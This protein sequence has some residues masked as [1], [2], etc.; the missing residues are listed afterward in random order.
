[1]R[2]QSKYTTMNNYNLKIGLLTLAAK[3]IKGIGN[4]FIRDHITNEEFF[5]SGV[6]SQITFLLKEK[7]EISEDLIYEV[8]ETSKEI[9]NI[10][11]EENIKILTFFDIDFP[12]N[13]KE[14]KNAPAL[15]FVKG[16]LNLL[17]ANTTCIIGTRKPNENGIRIT[18]K[19]SEHYVNKKWNICNG[20]ADGIDTAAIQNDGIY[21]SNVIGVVAGGLAF[22]TKKTLLKK[23]SIN[24]ENVIEAGGVIIS[25]FLPHEKETTFSVMKSCK[26]QADISDGLILIQSSVDGGSKYTLKS[27]CETGRPIAVINPVK[28]DEKLDSYSG[29]IA[30]RDNSF[31]GLSQITGLKTEKINTKSITVLNSKNDYDTFDAAINTKNQQSQMSKTL[32][33]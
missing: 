10:C 8:T 5:S 14:V 19:V 22:N 1:M 33:D 6:V 23:T 29:N 15:I 25:E 12:K 9:I 2:L 16:N 21:Y 32:F 18:Q 28:D 7:K 20:L 26:M 17:N 30:I 11:N 13:L 27:Y 3:E 4:V 24:A 31:K